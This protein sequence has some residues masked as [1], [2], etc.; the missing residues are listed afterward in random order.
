MPAR[1]RPPL[2]YRLGVMECR[3][4]GVGPLAP[5][6]SSRQK[7]G[8]KFNAAQAQS[9]RWKWVAHV[10]KQDMDRVGFVRASLWPDDIKVDPACKSGERSL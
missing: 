5:T 9:E 4:G 8:K 1:R 2:H 3:K 7:H 6:I 10:P